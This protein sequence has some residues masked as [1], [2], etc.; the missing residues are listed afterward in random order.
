MVACAGRCPRRAR[1]CRGT[2][3]TSP[4]TSSDAPPDLA[5]F[6]SNARHLQVIAAWHLQ[7]TTTSADTGSAVPNAHHCRA[8]GAPLTET[9][10]DLGATPLA[11]SYLEP[12]DRDRMEPH[13]PL[14]AR[15]CGVCLLVQ[16]PAVQTAEAIFSDY[17]Y[18]SSYSDSWVEHARALRRGDRAGAR[19]RARLAGRRGGLERRLPA[20]A[21]GR[22]RD[23]GAR[24]RA[25]RE[26]GR[27]GRRRAASTPRSRSSAVAYAADLVERRGHADLIVANNVLAHVPDLNDFLA[28]IAMLL[29][30]VGR[31]T[32]EA[33]HLLHLIR[34]RQFDTIYHEHFSYLSLLATRA[35]VARH[36]L[37]VVDVDELPTHGGSLR[38]HLAHAAAGTPVAP[39]VERVLADERAAGLATLD[40]YRGFAEAC[41]EVKTGLLA[42]PDRRP[43]R[44]SPRRRLRS[45]GQGQHAAHVLRRRPRADRVH[46]RSQPGQAGPPAAGLA[47]PDPRPGAA[48]RAPPGRRPDPALEPPRRDRRPAARPGRARLAARGGGAAPRGGR[49]AAAGGGRVNVRATGIEGVLVGSFEPVR[50]ERGA[51]ERM[52]DGDGAR[53]ARR[54][55]AARAVQPGAE[56][57]GRHAARPALAGRPRRRDEGG[58]L[59]SRR[60]LRRR[61]R[62]PARLADVRGLVR[63]SASHA[64]GNEMLIVP[65]GCAH[66]YVTL[67]DASDVAYWISVP[68]RPS[69]ARGV[70]YDDPRLAIDWP[71]DAAHR[72]RPR[73]RP[74]PGSTDAH[75]RHRWI[76]LRRPPGRAAARRRRPRRGGAVPRR[77]RP[78]RS[79]RAGPAGA[80]DRRG[81]ARPP[82]LGGRLPGTPTSPANPAWLFAA[83]SWRRAFAD[84]GG[85]RIV[86]AGSCAELD[87]ERP[88]PYADAKRALHLGL[89]ALAAT[90]GL[91]LAWARLFFLYGPG[92]HPER[93]VA[94]LAASLAAGREA[95]AS[96]GRQR[97]DY[98][99]VRDAGAAIALLATS[100]GDGP[101]RRRQRLGAGRRGHRSRR[102]P[103]RRPPGPPAA[104]RAAVA[105]RAPR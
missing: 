64:A 69:A 86:A 45:A 84:A 29:A 48:A 40:G 60:D 3:R 24:R 37:E 10:V 19:P 51:F 13:Y 25:G 88:T 76:G 22:V 49:R 105:R 33:P 8:C 100:R 96:T 92:E 28:G 78:A 1:H 38:Y 15:V 89:R 66:G 57:H 6:L 77:G 32:I 18:F 94:S 61:R 2:F 53:R 43:P 39:A 73:P 44:R 42:Y 7:D 70:R 11:N 82:R 75:P 50:D 47:D 74:P 83:S 46:R 68:Y 101:V 26:R 90:R 41:V 102:W 95:L 59:R 97:R 16:L 72:L 104:R 93:L 17:A 14:H 65:P 23:P 71:V 55:S 4:G 56:R 27:R 54:R 99:D 62:R 81:R 80:A 5:M 63:R 31:V 21:P 12:D 34:E 87:L 9:F 58:A 98:L 52:W 20:P 67:E 36:G 79:R 30:P 91:E 85:R 103:R 35:A